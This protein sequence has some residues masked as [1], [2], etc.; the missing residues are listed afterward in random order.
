MNKHE[1]IQLSLYSINTLSKI[2]I[3]EDELLIFYELSLVHKKYQKELE[4]WLIYP[5]YNIF[6]KFSKAR[7]YVNDIIEFCKNYDIEYS[8]EKI[9]TNN[10][11]SFRERFNKTRDF[12]RYHYKGT[13][14]TKCIY[15]I[16]PA[17]E[18]DDIHIDIMDN[19][20]D[21]LNLNFD[22]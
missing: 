8:F 17:K 14:I 21:I 12:V 4:E 2:G 11:N 3:T 19:D 13:E 1:Y 6:G 9:D 10:W 7:G 16:K 15:F 22:E 20:E 5:N 18:K